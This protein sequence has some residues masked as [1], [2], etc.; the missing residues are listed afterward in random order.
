MTDKTTDK[1]MKTAGS[2]FD[3]FKKFAFKGNVI[4]MA[5]GVIIGGAFGKIVTSIVNDIVM[6]PLSILTGGIKFSELRFVLKQA[7]DE[8]PALTLNYGAFIQT[9]IDFFLIALSVYLFI[10]IISKTK[11]KF[12]KK[13]AEISAVVAPIEPPKPTQEELLTEIRDILKNK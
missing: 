3:D 10:K 5:V 12:E 4:D 9:V 6:P 8:N 13:E 11:S 2:A 7:T 1:I